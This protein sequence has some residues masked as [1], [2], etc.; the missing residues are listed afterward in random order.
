MKEDQKGFQKSSMEARDR[1]SGNF[2]NAHHWPRVKDRRRP[3]MEKYAASTN[4]KLKH[5]HLGQT[6]LEL[7]GF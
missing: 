3:G 2:K 7:H 6:S 5:L 4:I 1:A